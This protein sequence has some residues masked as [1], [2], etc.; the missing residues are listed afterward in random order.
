MN[1]IA[2][3]KV[4]R[5]GSTEA[6]KFID[7]MLVTAEDLNAATHYPLAVMQVLMRSYFGCGIVCGLDVTLPKRNAEGS[8]IVEIGRGVAL[9]CDGYPIEL[10]RMLPFDFSPDPCGCP[11]APG[12]R[13]VKY[14]AMRRDAAPEAPPRPCGCGP[15]AGEPGQCSRLRDHVHVQAFDEE[16]LPAGICM[17]PAVPPPPPQGQP[18]PHVHSGACECMSHCPDCDPCA[19]PWVLLATV[20]VNAE[21][22]AVERINADD[23][24]SIHGGPRWVKPIAC[25]CEGERRAKPDYAEQYKGLEERLL[26]LDG[27][28][29]KL[30][31]RP[32]AGSAGPV[33]SGATNAPEA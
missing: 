21:T 6:V 10:C 30:E 16:D 19:E 33:A 11:A 18:Q 9:G 22:V 2:K 27:R 1:Q 12:A 7:G 17:K 4:S 3:H 25:L 26:V 24:V 28:L 5:P 20:I 15:A 29:K 14:I 31:A 32:A 13:I 23:D 8:L